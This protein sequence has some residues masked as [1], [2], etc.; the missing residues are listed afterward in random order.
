MD[1]LIIAGLAVPMESFDRLPDR[2]R[3]EVAIA[4]D[5]TLQDGTDLPM[6]EYQGKTISIPKAD[7]AALR[8]AVGAGPVVCSGPLLDTSPLTCSVLVANAPRERTG[9]T[10]FEVALS[11]TLRQT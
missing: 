6:E 1:L 2:R 4:F 7:A 5:N 3:G 9:E 8:A 10:T 11:L